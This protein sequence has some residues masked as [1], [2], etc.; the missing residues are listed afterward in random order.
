MPR[1]LRGDT[2]AD[3]RHATQATRDQPAQH[4]HPR[5]I[6]FRERLVLPELGVGTFPQV[7]GHQ[8]RHRTGN[9]T[10]PAFEAMHTRVGFAL[11][12]FENPADMPVTTRGSVHRAIGVVAGERHPKGLEALGFSDTA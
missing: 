7:T 1:L 3:K 8:R 9:D 6:L 11:E 2:L 4:I 10:K 5:G 12:Q